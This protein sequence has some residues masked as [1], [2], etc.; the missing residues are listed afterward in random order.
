[1]LNEIKCLLLNG[2]YYPSL[3]CEVFQN[4]S[5]LI[6]KYRISEKHRDFRN[7][8][9][10]YQKLRYHKLVHGIFFGKCKVFNL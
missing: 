2:I 8:I 4:G 10:T 1:M 7:S 3:N 5:Y 9:T 6:Q